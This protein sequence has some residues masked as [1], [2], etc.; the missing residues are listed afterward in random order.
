MHIEVLGPDINESGMYFTVNKEGAIRFG[1]AALKG[2]GEGPVEAILQERVTDPFT[3][4]FDMTRRLNL[5]SVNKKAMESLVYGGALDTFGL[6]RAQYLAPTKAFNTLIEHAIKYGNKQQQFE[7]ESKISLFQDVDTAIDEPAIP[8]CDEWP[9]IEKLTK[10]K[11]VTGIFISGHPLDDYKVE[12]ENFTTISLDQIEN[13][14]NVQL[15]LAGLIVKADHRVS[16]RGDGWARITIQD[17]RGTLEFALWKE[18]YKKF[19][20][21][22]EVGE[23]IFLEGIYKKNYRG[24]EYVFEVSDIKLLGSVGDLKT[25]SITL[26]LPVGTISDKFIEDLESLCLASRGSHLLKVL[27][28]DEEEDLMISM[29][30]GS[31]KV[32]ADHNF[33]NKIHEMGIGYK[34]N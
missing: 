26:R 8:A 29:V 5:R 15:S 23:A 25:K 18:N 7:E 16:Q 24:T 32:N 20:E 27:V 4:I 10:E 28:M 9:L 33:I 12:I 2:V 17:Y 14:K 11:E 13:A 3:S 1:L 19:R 30:S 6:H 34:I 21:L 22:C 31:R